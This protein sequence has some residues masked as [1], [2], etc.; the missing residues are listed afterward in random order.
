MHNFRTQTA[1]K[2]SV[3]CT[4]GIGKRFA[5]WALHVKSMKMLH[6]PWNDLIGATLLRVGVPQSGSKV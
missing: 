4:V 5:K 3:G 2:L 1:H 6:P